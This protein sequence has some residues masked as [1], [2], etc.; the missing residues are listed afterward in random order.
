MVDEVY[1]FYT[2]LI[3]N[4]LNQYGFISHVHKNSDIEFINKVSC[5]KKKHNSL[6]AKIMMLKTTKQMSW[7]AQMIQLN[8]LKNSKHQKV[9]FDTQPSYCKS[10]ILKKIVKRKLQ[11]R[12]P[13]WPHCENRFER[14]FARS[15][16]KVQE[17]QCLKPGR[18]KWDCC[19]GAKEGVAMTSTLDLQAAHV[20]PYLR[21]DQV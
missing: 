20:K 8:C 18:W 10:F 13:E 5:N 2:F 12:K 4:W 21:S 17:N 15:K 9:I 3:L 14:S 1:L 16:I 7:L 19:W 6:T 11:R